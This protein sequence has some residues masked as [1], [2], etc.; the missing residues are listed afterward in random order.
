MLAMEKG[1]IIR[2]EC[3][4]HIIGDCNFIDRFVDDRGKFGTAYIQES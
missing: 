3:S 4:M 1:V 2:I